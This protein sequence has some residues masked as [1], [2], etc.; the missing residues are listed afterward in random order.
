VPEL[1][2]RSAPAFALEVAHEASVVRALFGMVG[3]FDILANNAGVRQRTFVMR[4]RPDNMAAGRRRQ[5][6]WRVP[7][8]EAVPGA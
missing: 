2:G 7:V 1:L 5:S 8:Y 6:D 4:F 3:R